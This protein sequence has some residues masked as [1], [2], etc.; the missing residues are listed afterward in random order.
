M[1]PIIL[2]ASILLGTPQDKP[3]QADVVNA[4]NA[5]KL[6]EAEGNVSRAAELMGMAERT[7]RN[8]LREYR[9]AAHA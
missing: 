7:L 4:L 2:I 6:D 5:G 8:R 3:T 9:G 1:S